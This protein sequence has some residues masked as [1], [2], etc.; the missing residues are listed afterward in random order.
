[1]KH[2]STDSIRRVREKFQ[3]LSASYVTQAVD[4]V[5]Q[6]VLFFKFEYGACAVQ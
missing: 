1:M 4:G 5:S 6:E 3:A 2:V